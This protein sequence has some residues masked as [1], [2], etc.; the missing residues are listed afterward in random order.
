MAPELVVGTMYDMKV[1]IWS[2]GIVAL[3][4]ADGE[5]PNLRLNPMKA[6]YMIASG[7]APTF[8]VPSK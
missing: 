1:D 6:L 2:L 3:E 8:Q 7:P 4:L 5:P